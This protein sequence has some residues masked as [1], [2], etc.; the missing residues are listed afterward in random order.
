MEPH[1]NHKLNWN[2]LVDSCKSN[3]LKAISGDCNKIHL[4]CRDSIEK[5]IDK[6]V[7][8]DLI[9]MDYNCKSN[10]IVDFFTE[11]KKKIKEANVM[12]TYNIFLISDYCFKKNDT[13]N[14]NFIKVLDEFANTYLDKMLSLNNNT[15]TKIKKDKLT[16]EYLYNM[17]ERY[18]VNGNALYP[19]PGEF[20]WDILSTEDDENFRILL[21][22]YDNWKKSKIVDDEM[23]TD[24]DP[25]TFVSQYNMYDGKITKYYFHKLMFLYLNINVNIKLGSS[26]KIRNM[27]FMKEI[28][29]YYYD[30]VYPSTFD[31]CFDKSRYLKRDKVKEYSKRLFKNL[32]TLRALWLFITKKF[33]I[34]LTPGEMWGG[35]AYIGLDKSYLRMYKDYINDGYNLFPEDENYRKHITEGYLGK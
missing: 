13:F 35:D 2:L 10:K 5:I 3:S 4:T 24:L 33:K 29:K 31:E 9:C 27:K 19:K 6:K 1:L 16:K 17:N 26:D 30:I 23:K 18:C 8:R 14:R 28:S 32:Y 15:K 22:F 34:N 12:D 25:I 7:S 21:Y 20:V 11:K